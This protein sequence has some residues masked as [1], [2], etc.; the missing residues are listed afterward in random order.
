MAWSFVMELEYVI[1]SCS[2]TFVVQIIKYWLTALRRYDP[3]FYHH[4]LKL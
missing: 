4:L 1:H 3:D 2:Q